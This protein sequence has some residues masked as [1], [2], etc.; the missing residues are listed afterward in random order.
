M[1]QSRVDGDFVLIPLGGETY[2]YGR[3]LPDAV[4]AFYD[5]FDRG[6]KSVDELPGSKILFRIPVMDHAIKN[7]R[8]PVIGHLPLEQGLRQPARFFLVDK[9]KKGDYRIY[10][11]GVIR[12]ATR[13]ECIGL[14]NAAVWEPEQVEDRLRDHIA[15]RPNKWVEALKLV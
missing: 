2:G 6:K 11:N 4:V 12:R 8:W 10:E 7:C 3:V 9:L 13:Q 15:E 1:K 14:E 5:A